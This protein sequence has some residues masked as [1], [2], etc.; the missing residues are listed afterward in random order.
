MYAPLKTMF[1]FNFISKFWNNIKG[2]LIQIWKSR[3][4]FVF[5]KNN[6]LKILHS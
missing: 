2:T 1:M 4:M 3:Y 6:T 5:I